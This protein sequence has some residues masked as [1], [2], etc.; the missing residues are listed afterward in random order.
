MPAD[1]FE[2]AYGVTTAINVVPSDTVN[3][4]FGF[5]IGTTVTFSSLPAGSSLSG[6]TYLISATPTNN[7]FNITTLAGGAVSVSNSAITANTTKVSSGGLQ[8]TISA[9]S[10]GLFTYIN[11]NDGGFTRGLYVGGTGAL[12]VRMKDGQD[13]TFAK[14]LAGSFLP[15]VVSRVYSTGTTG[16]EIIALK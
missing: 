7:K 12:K 3:L 2:R 4:E 13:I 5:S 14:I 15:I 8:A 10:S 9:L 16:T 6:Q 11:A 1:T